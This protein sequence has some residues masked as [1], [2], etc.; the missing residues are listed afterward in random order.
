MP[1][2]AALATDYDGTLALHGHVDATTLE[3][4]RLWQSSGRTLI[5]VTGRELP[6]LMEVCPELDLFDLIVAENGALLYRPSDRS[7]TL[8]ADPP[9]PEFAA[10]LIAQGAERVSIGRVVVATWRPHEHTAQKLISEMGLPLEVILNKSAV[11]AL[12]AGVNKASGLRTALNHL[13]ID[14]SRTVAIGDAEN[15]LA[16]LEMCGLGAAV[17]NALPVLKEAAEIITRTERGEGVAELIDLLL[18]SDP[19][20]PPPSP[21]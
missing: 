17:A 6:E 10:R 20:N 15:D 21:G 3:A 4:L 2:F 16:L 12:P 11:M 19:V 18:A 14:P 1:S 8:L 5:L 9:P 13:K 7:E